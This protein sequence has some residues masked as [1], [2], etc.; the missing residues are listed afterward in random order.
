M[1]RI[2][3]IEGLRCFLAWWVV[4]GHFVW[5]TDF[6][7]TKHPGLIHYPSL[8]FIKFCGH[9]WCAVE[10]FMIISG[11]VIF[12]L[13]DSQKTSY[14]PFI[15]GRFF[16][17][18][19]LYLVC[20]AGA[21]LLAPVAQSNLNHL[22]SPHNDFASRLYRIHEWHT[23]FLTYAI[24]TAL[25]LQGLIPGNVVPFIEN[26]FL[27]PTWSLT[28]EWQFYLVAPLLYLGL[29]KWSSTACITLAII[30]VCLVIGPKMTW[31]RALLLNNLVWFVVGFV[32]YRF[33]RFMEKRKLPLVT[34]KE[35]IIALL[36]LILLAAVRNVSFTIW[37]LVFVATFSHY[38][39]VRIPW[40]LKWPSNLIR[41]VLNHPIAQLLGKV[42]YSTYLVHWLVIDGVIWSLLKVDHHL[43]STR[44]FFYATLPVIILTAL[45]S[46][47]TYELIEK[48][49]MRLG[50]RLLERR[51][52]FTSLANIACEKGTV[53]Q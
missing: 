12:Y 13:L 1:R 40:F 27:A 34:R 10:V 4:L 32:S 14:L 43:S 15:V 28:L 46:L 33:F 24:P 17:L 53:G 5:L 23:H 22:V 39:F 6:A 26:I 41:Y 25:M 21:I 50:K 30:F 48:P 9:S 49:G 42:S 52:D 11:F 3:E 36:G 45:C 2:N 51:N 37:A 35:R 29:K 44:L 47:L 20:I 7:N 31:N 8:V 38:L 18:F 16:R 19:P